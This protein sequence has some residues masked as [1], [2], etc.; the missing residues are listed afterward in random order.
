MR[1]PLHETTTTVNVGALF[2]GRTMV[3]WPNKRGGWP[4]TG[5]KQQYVDAPGERRGYREPGSKNVRTGR[6]IVKN[7]VKGPWDWDP[8]EGPEKEGD[9]TLDTVPAPPKVDAGPGLA[10]MTTGANIAGTIQPFMFTAKYPWP[11]NGYPQTVPVRQVKKYR[12][13]RKAFLNPQAFLYTQGAG[14]IG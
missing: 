11:F 12:N 5:L 14:L 4:Y 13:D 9:D 2:S 3:G 6:Q 8:N 1:R 7:Q 10:E